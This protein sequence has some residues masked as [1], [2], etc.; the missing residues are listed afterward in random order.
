[1]GA[2]A[3]GGEAFN[4]PEAPGPTSALRLPQQLVGLYQGP[5][6]PPV[7]N[8]AAHWLEAMSG[9]QRSHAL[10]Q[11]LCLASFLVVFVT[12]FFKKRKISVCIT[13]SN[14]K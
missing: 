9:T 13:D 2:E 6:L 4:A 7:R 3:A 14:F 10:C 5:V 11:G 12:K 8:P 1:M